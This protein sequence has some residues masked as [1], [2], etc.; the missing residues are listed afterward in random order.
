[1]TKADLQSRIATAAQGEL[2]GPQ[3]SQGNSP[4]LLEQ[5]MAAGEQRAE[6][7]IGRVEYSEEEWAELMELIQAWYDGDNPVLAEMTV[8]TLQKEIKRFMPRT[9][10]PNTFIKYLQ[11]NNLMPNREST[12]K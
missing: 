4:R 2:G 3:T 8:W 6:R 5:I 7:K 10:S 11:D 1:M 12:D 9:P